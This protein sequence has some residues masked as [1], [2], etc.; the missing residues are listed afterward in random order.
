MSVGWQ[1]RRQRWNQREDVRPPGAEYQREMDDTVFVLRSEAFSYTTQLP[2]Q[3]KPHRSGL[4]Q[5]PFEDFCWAKQRREKAGEENNNRMKR[6][7][8]PFSFHYRVL[9]FDSWQE[10]CN[11]NKVNAQ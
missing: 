9:G 7:L 6:A 3:P 11:V 10:G 2:H 1:K 8:H 5:R 4:E